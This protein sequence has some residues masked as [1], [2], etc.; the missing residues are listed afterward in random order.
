VKLSETQKHVAYTLVRSFKR[1][2]GDMLDILEEMQWRLSEMH[3]SL[4][5]ENTITSA[6]DGVISHQEAKK[7]VRWYLDSF[8]ACGGSTRSSQQG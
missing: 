6:G 2:E 4:H 7:N 1:K 3:A 8:S 5:D